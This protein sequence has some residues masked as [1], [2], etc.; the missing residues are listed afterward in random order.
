MRGSWHGDGRPVALLH[1]QPGRGSEW[2]PVVAALKGLRVVAPDRPG[3][4]GTSAQDFA[5]NASALAALA[6][7][8]DVERLV[9]VGHS[10][11]GG[12]ALELALNHPELVAGLCLIGSVGSPLAIHPTD[13]L[14]A[15]PGIRRLA[16][17]VVC[18]SAVLSPRSF[19]AATG[20]SLPA[21]DRRQVR[22]A[23]MRWLRE[24]AASSFALEQSYLVRDSADLAARL[25]EVEVPSLV[26]TGGSDRTVSPAAAADLAA[27]LP[28]SQLRTVPGGH[29]L[30]AEAPDL[31]VAAVQEIVS[32]AF[33]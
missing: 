11:G 5:G 25:G 10:W 15:L 8:S 21:T 27:R 31:V 13:R 23:G 2:D 16:G 29:L 1:G 30:P 33:W 7:A 9:V 6:R 24:G 32:H 4:D 18:G 17:V 12:V 22:R 28:R 19:V 14:L 20:S 3:Y 26:L